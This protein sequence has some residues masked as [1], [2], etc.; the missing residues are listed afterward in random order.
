MYT[1]NFV[2]SDKIVAKMGTFGRSV[3]RIAQGCWMIFDREYGD[4]V[5]CLK[6]SDCGLDSFHDWVVLFAIAVVVDAAT[7]LESV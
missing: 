6:D 3:G 1:N 4:W 2:L 5:T 7:E